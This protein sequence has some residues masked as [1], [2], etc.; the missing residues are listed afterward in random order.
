MEVEIVR[1]SGFPFSASFSLI[2]IYHLQTK[3]KKIKQKKQFSITWG[4]PKGFLL[5]AQL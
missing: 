3:K 5:T 1:Q 4:E 2:I